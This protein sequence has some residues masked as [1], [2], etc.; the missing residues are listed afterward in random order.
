LNNS[1][2]KSNIV[3]LIW[4]VI[5]IAGEIILWIK[6]NNIFL[7]IVAMVVLPIFIDIILS[8]FE[9]FLM[10]KRNK[11]VEGLN[12]KQSFTFDEIDVSFLNI[13][14]KG[15]KTKSGIYL[16]ITQV[17]DFF[18]KYISQKNIRWMIYASDSS[19]LKSYVNM[20]PG[21]EPI[22][23]PYENED[24]SNIE[25]I[26]KDNFDITS[27][28]EKYNINT[29]EIFLFIN[30]R[31]VYNRLKSEFGKR[32]PDAKFCIVQEE[33]LFKRPRM[34]IIQKKVEGVSL[35]NLFYYNRQKLEEKRHDISKLIRKYLNNSDIDL[36]I[37]NFIYSSN[38]KLYY[39]DNKPTY[40]NTKRVNETNRTSISE[41]IL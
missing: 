17:N 10:V 23:Y 35:W 22:R 27:I 13:I 37:K 4:F 26:L 36:N 16:H 38:N 9:S 32:I 7:R 34:A 39:I 19:Y 40:V 2:K 20:M 5:F 25:I 33:R 24:I 12:N 21:S 14:P 28:A 1:K 29:Q 18:V 3:S 8:K 11:N 30:M 41:S 6:I 31:T 15:K